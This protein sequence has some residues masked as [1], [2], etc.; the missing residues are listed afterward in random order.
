V[1]ATLGSQV[2]DYAQGVATEQ[3][4]VTFEEIK[5][6]RLSVEQPVR[7]LGAPENPRSPRRGTNWRVLATTAAVVLI[8]AG[9]VALLP[10]LLGSGDPKAPDAAIDPF[11]DHIWSQIMD[12]TGAFDGPS[13]D[14]G[15]YGTRMTSVSSGGPGLVAVGW[16]G[17]AAS[18]DATVWTSV[19]GFVWTRVAEHESV[20]GGAGSQVMLAVADGGPGL[21]AVG[22]DAPSGIDSVPAVWASVDGITWT[23]VPLDESRARN[24]GGGEMTS[25]VVGGPGLVAVGWVGRGY[26]RVA[27]VWTSVDGITWNAVPDDGSVFG[28]GDDTFNTRMLSVTEGGPGLVAVGA[29]GSDLGGSAEV[30]T[31]TDGLVWN[32]V[33]HDG[34]LFDGS[35]RSVATGGV[36]LVAV[37]YGG[38]QSANAA[39]WS[40]IDGRSWS[41]L[42]DDDSVFGGSGTQA[43]RSV[44]A[45]EVGLV[46]VGSSG[47]GGAASDV[48]E[49]AAVWTSADGTEWGR[50]A[51]QDSV[52]RGFGPGPRD[53]DRMMNAVV[54]T[55]FGLVAV[56]SD[57]PRASVWLASPGN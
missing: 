8:F 16:G 28:E 44:T 19:E 48:A 24:A 54:A 36:G 11:A 52:F 40:S 15:G 33:P 51:D 20:F 9:G 4:P 7:P 21:V 45:T 35:M 13:H 26:S 39:V 34:S 18:R 57:W 1:N 38:W 14:Q 31:S 17:P 29:S 53:G 50:V 25:V 56:G 37:G 46:A 5:T 55:E 43:M 32:R 27:A 49:A 42:P 47:S 12:D 41:R 10:R 2:F 3:R 6:R 22:S 23:R 30:W